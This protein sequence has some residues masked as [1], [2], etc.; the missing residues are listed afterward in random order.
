MEEMSVMSNIFYKPEDAYVGD[1]IPYYEEGEFKLFYLHGWRENYDISRD[2]G[3]FLLS[4]KDFLSFKEH[5][6]CK[7]QGGTG[8]IIKKDEIYHMFYCEFPE[9]RQIACH[10]V[11]N[12][13]LKWTK[14]PEDSFGPDEDIY[15]PTD[16]RDPHVFWNEEAKEYWMLIAARVKGPSNRKGGI[17][18]CVSKDLKDW[19]VKEPLYA[20][21]IHVS[22]HECPD[23]FKIGDWWYLIY[24]A[25]TDKF[26]TFYR[27]SKSPNGPWITPEVDTF[28]GRAFY[29]AKSGTDGSNFYIF[30]WNPTK[31]DNI[32]KWNPEAYSGND[33]NTWDWGGNLV[34]HQLVQQADGTLYVKVPDTID[35][36]FSKQIVQS[37]VPVIGQWS[38]NDNNL[39]TSSKYSFSCVLGGDLPRVCKLGGKLKYKPNTKAFGLVLRADKSVDRAYY[40]RLEPHRNRVVFSSHIMQSEEGGK[41]LPYEVEIERPINLVPDTEYEVKVFVEDTI[42]EFYIDNKVAL[43][44]RIYDIEAGKWGVFVSEGEADFKALNLSVI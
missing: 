4:T 15:E 38:I 41:T 31:T 42:C 27:M 5:G 3:W 35:K 30:G 20:P 17:A 16:W 25:Y 32:F 13:L 7:I 14:I 19:E 33:Y 1:F 28:D 12:D 40:F 23:I 11:S 24:S 18:L 26:A 39:S 29:A 10:A 43:S 9:N 34:V 2:I 6:A 44:T 37:F 21:N 36:K 22:A 8:S